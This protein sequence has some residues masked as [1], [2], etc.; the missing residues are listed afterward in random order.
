MKLASFV[1]LGAALAAACSSSDGP[2]AGGPTPP[3]P[4]APAPCAAELPATLSVSEGGLLVLRRHEGIGYEGAGGAVATVYGDDVLVRAPYVSNGAEARIAL[5]CGRTI[6]LALRPLTWSQLATWTED[7]GA[8][9]REYGAWWIDGAGAGALVVFGGY[10]YVPKQFT[11]ANDAWRFDFAK[12]AWSPLAGDNLP[13]LP[14]GRAAPI[15]GERAVLYFGGSAP[16]ANG[17]IDTP[18]S[19]YRFDFDDARL[20]PKKEENVSRAPGAYTGSFLFDAKRKRWLAICGLDTSSGIHCDVDSYSVQN[21]F[22]RLKTTG[23]RPSGRFGFHYGYDEANDRVVLFG[24]QVGDENLDLDGETWTLELGSEP[25]AWKRLFANGEGPL[26]RRNGAFALDPVGRRFF[27]WGGT[28][29]GRTS[30]KGIQVLTLDRGAEAWTNVDTPA[31]VLARTSGLGVHDPSR[32]RIVFG[33]GNGPMPLRDLWALDLANAS[34][35]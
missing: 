3:E 23:A 13:L 17:S 18:P 16:T 5:S 32:D 1:I 11:P 35:R 14:G 8:K 2:T 20:T 15:P 19:L 10:H 7:T 4:A 6:A 21:G 27:V 34:P 33:F 12:G 9:A 24:G 30:A 22:Q 26:K 29:D 28:P 31:E 25:P